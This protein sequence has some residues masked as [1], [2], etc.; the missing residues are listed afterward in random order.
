MHTL[1][2]KRQRR[3]QLSQ[4]ALMRVSH[5]GDKESYTKLVKSLED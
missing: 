4:L 3:N 1:Q 5:G 2:S